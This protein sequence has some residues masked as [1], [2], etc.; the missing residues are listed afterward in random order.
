MSWSLAEE[1]LQLA[2]IG[3]GYVSYDA[4]GLS[5]ALEVDH[6]SKNA[7]WES[8]TIYCWQVPLEAGT[9]TLNLQFRQT[10]GSILEHTWQFALSDE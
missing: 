2:V 1:R 9:H 6:I 8:H 7:T 3:T 5:G 4:E 10:S